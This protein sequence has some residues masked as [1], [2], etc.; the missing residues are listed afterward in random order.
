[1][2]GS[3]KKGGIRRHANFSVPSKM[4]QF[5]LSSKDVSFTKKLDFEYV[6]NAAQDAVNLYKEKISGWVG[7]AGWGKKW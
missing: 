5:T 7:G 2:G 6:E 4:F 1:M 3:W